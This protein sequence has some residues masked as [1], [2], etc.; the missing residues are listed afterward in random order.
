MKRCQQCGCS[1]NETES[2]CAVDGSPLESLP[3]KNYKKRVLYIVLPAAVLYCTGMWAII[4]Y[5]G[6]LA[7]SRKLNAEKAEEAEKTIK[8]IVRE[9]NLAQSDRER[10]CQEYRETLIEEVKSESI[11]YKDVTRGDFDWD[12][13][14]IVPGHPFRL[15]RPYQTVDSIIKHLGGPDAMEEKDEVTKYTW[16][17]SSLREYYVSKGMREATEEEI[18]HNNK[19]LEEAL[20]IYNDYWKDKYKPK[21]QVVVKRTTYFVVYA[22][23]NGYI[24]E[25]GFSGN[26]FWE[27][28]G[29]TTAD[30]RRMNK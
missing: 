3:K 7:Y 13:G 15:R 21:L 17:V 14:K 1:Y 22:K 2:F 29:L 18:A 4:S 20:R 27:E 26:G 6:R 25:V 23:G 12:K 5:Q 8:D 9:E 19:S 11:I 24:Y 10:R 16:M 30:W 28:I